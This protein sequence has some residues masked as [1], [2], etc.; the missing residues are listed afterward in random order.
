VRAAAPDDLKGCIRLFGNGGLF[1]Y[2]GL[3]RTS[4]LGKCSWYVTNRDNA[5]VLITSA[6][7]V[8]L[9]PDD[10]NGFVA[11]IRT[12]ASIP[13]AQRSEPASGSA[14]SIRSGGLPGKIIGVAIGI[15]VILL[16]AGSLLYS[17]GPP[18]YTL[19]PDGLTIHDRF[20]PVTLKAADVDIERVQVVDIDANTDWR[21]TM[22][23]NGFSNMHYHAGWFKVGNGKKVR[24]YRADGRRL[25]LFPPKADGAP[26]LVE[27][28]QPEAFIQKMRQAWQ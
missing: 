20:Y 8:I 10:V 4:K 25:V 27:V 18:R 22:R 11:T 21:P 3:F 15:L 9:S 16:V 12:I 7:T 19:T 28:S 1:G 26:V 23:T 13:N 2:Y 17:P 5:V 6:K 24:M 14:R